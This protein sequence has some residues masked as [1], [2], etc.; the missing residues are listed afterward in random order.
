MTAAPQTTLPDVLPI[1]TP[2]NGIQ[3]I[4]KVDGNNKLH[5]V[6]FLGE[7]AHGD[8]FYVTSPANNPTAFSKPIRVNHTS[9]SACALGTIRGA[10]MSVTDDGKVFVVWNGSD[11]T[12]KDGVIPFMFS[13]INKER[14]AFLPERNLLG[15]AEYIDGGGAIA[16]D[17]SSGVYAVWHACA[18]DG[19]EANGRVYI[20]TSHDDGVSFSAANAIS[21]RQDGTCACCAMT[22]AYA[23]GKLFILYRRAKGSV[24]RDVI[25]MISSD[26]GRTFKSNLLTAFSAEAC[27]MSLFALAQRGS[28]VEAA[29]ETGDGIETVSLATKNAT[30]QLVAESSKYP[31]MVLGPD[32]TKLLTFMRGAGWARGGKAHWQLLDKD[33]NVLDKSDD[34]SA[35]ISQA[36]SFAAPVVLGR[37]KYGFIY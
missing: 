5:L 6:Y 31:M 30:P 10:Q 2:E 14:T 36:W 32:G 1:R 26:G 21:L 7:P 23:N 18:K 29:W 15:G 33:M 19:N 20:S 34:R 27:P 11:R 16:T 8:L 13:R 12:V 9:G 3:P 37:G 35:V 25:E 22:A 4:A 24:S 28:D 17:S